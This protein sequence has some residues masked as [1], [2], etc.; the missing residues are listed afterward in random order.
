MCHPSR[1]ASRSSR[2]MATML[3]V[4]LVSWLG[5][6]SPASATSVET[7]VVVTGDDLLVHLQALQDI[8]DANDG[9]RAL[10]TPGY[11]DSVDYVLGRLMA[12]GLEPT[13]QAFQV[14]DVPI[15]RAPPSFLQVAPVAETYVEEVDFVQPVPGPSNAVEG[16]V[17]MV[18]DSCNPEAY[19]EL[20]EGSV[21]LVTLTDQ[22]D[23]RV[24]QQAGFNRAEA[25]VFAPAGGVGQPPAFV[26]LGYQQVNLQ[27]PALS[28]S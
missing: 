9:T 16:Q 27:M 25:M 11:Q 5:V 18:E 15:R 21:A 4:G 24:Q 10:A 12:A 22:C 7:M 20:P 19:D 17:V 3:V 6:P 14:D 2:A 1:R 8:A 13:V 26:E 28:I 23:E